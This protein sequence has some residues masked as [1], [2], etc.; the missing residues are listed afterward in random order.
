MPDP[1]TSLAQ[2]E[3]QKKYNARQKQSGYYQTRPWIPEELR[4]WHE[5]FV[6]SARL[7][8]EHGIAIK[9]PPLPPETKG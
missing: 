4:G 8:K 2:R 6:R 1:K 3:A 5:A 7:W 9:L